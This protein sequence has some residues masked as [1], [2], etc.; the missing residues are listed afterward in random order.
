[1]TTNA[2][3]DYQIIIEALTEAQSTLSIEQ[4][5]AALAAL[6]RIRSY[7]VAIAVLLHKQ[8]VDSHEPQV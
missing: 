8:V 6:E 3:K 7:V 4:L 1:M 5:A 2:E